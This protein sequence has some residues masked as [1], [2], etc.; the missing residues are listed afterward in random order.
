MA[1]TIKEIQQ[2]MI[3]DLTARRS[4][5]STSSVA[6]WR[7]WVWVV[8]T[9]IHLFEVILDQFRAEIDAAADKITPGTVR[10]YIDQCRRFQNGHKLLFNTGTAQMYYEADDAQARIVSVVSV[11]EDAKKLTI[12]AAKMSDASKITPLTADELRNFTGYVESIKFAGME[13]VVISRTADAIRYELAVYYDPVVPATTVRDTVQAQIDAFRT[14]LDFNSMFYRQRLV[15][16]IMS[17]DGVVTADLQSVE[18][19]GTD[20]EDFKPVGIAEELDAGY[21]D[22]AEG[23]VLN[24]VSIKGSEHES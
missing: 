21:F 15:D 6:E 1:R 24:L 22:Y 7:L 11:R 18:R 17:V 23:C 3:A 9:A 13:T 14:S 16:A 10:W 20:M 12:K 5:L 2:A 8:A 19:K 4:G